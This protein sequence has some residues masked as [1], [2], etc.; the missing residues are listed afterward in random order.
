M[1]SSI[2]TKFPQNTRKIYKS[3][4][5]FLY[6]NASLTVKKA[7]FLSSNEIIRDK[8]L[9]GS[10]EGSYSKPD[11]SDLKLIIVNIELFN[12]TDDE[13]EVDLTTLHI[14][15]N[16]FSSQFDMIPM[17]YLNDCGMYI[18]L[19]ANERKFLKMPVPICESFFSKKAWKNLTNRQYYIVSTLYPQK[20]MTEI[21]FE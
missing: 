17:M 10:L 16:D 9:L 12:S 11:A 3:N 13:I 4:E 1:F 19:K 6:Q 15:S 21:T 7:E 2:N 5:S 20:T 18:N 8:D 14:E